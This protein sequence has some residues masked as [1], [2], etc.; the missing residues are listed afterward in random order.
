VIADADGLLAARFAAT[1]DRHDDSNWNDVLRRR[2][3][4]R[5][6]RPRALL[7]A[8]AVIAVVVPAA[9]AFGGVIRDLFEGTPPPPLVQEHF[10]RWNELA[11]RPPTPAPNNWFPVVDT[12]KAH[13]VLAVET[14]DGPL[15]LWAAPSA[16]GRGCWLLQFARDANPNNTVYG[17]SGCRTRPPSASEIAWSDFVNDSHPSLRILVGEAFGNAAS[18]VVDLADNSTLRL[19]VIE[20]FFLATTAQEATITRVTSYDRAGTQLAESTHGG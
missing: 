10:S 4:R 7:V 15:Y 19:P 1:A 16:D 20:N 8:V 5:I 14:S 18:V 12:S 11:L 3:Q 9:I 17:P 2:E 6:G 13:G